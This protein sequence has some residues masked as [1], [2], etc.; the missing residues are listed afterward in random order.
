[1]AAAAPDN[2]A[3]EAAA[4]RRI[5]EEVYRD[6]RTGFGS[7]ANTLKAAKDRNPFVT[8]KEVKDFLETLRERQ[9][10]PQRGYNSFVP[11]EP[12]H[13]VQVDLAY[14]QAFGGKPYPYMLVAIDSFSKKVAAI[15]LKDRLATTTATAMKIII[16]RLG[17]PSQVYSDDGAEFKKEFKQLLDDWSV[18]KQVTRGHAFFVERAIRTIKE[19]IL[20]RL[21]QN[22]GR[23]GQWHLLLPDIVNQINNRVHTATGVTPNEAYNNPDKATQ[24]WESMKGRAKNTAEPREIIGPGDRVKIRLKPQESRASYRVNELKWSEKTYRVLS[25]EHTNLG[26]RYRLEGWPEPLVRRD[27]RKISAA[28]DERPRGLEVQTRQRRRQQAQAARLPPMF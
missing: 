14:M 12:M 22:V 1:M 4:R 19:A 15:P 5:I 16:D 8:R 10:R 13:E 3:R 6:P 18:D 2:L 28:E 20:P 23:R 27:I 17:I 9:D 11:Q 21:A 25:A 7:I 26:P 24:A